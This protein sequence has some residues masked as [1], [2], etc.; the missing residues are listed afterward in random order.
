MVATAARQN[1][2]IVVVGDDGTIFAN[3]VRDLHFVG[4]TQQASFD[5]G[6]HV[7]TVTS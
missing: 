7:Y 1:Q 6:G 2:E 5:G 4:G 3:T